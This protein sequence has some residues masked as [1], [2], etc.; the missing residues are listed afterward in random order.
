MDDKITRDRLSLLPFDA[1]SPYLAGAVYVYVE[2][3]PANEE[4]IRRLITRYAGYP[5]FRG[6]VAL[7]NSEV[8][9]MGFGTQ[10]LPGQWWHDKVAA[11]VGSKHAA[12]QDAWVLVDLA[13][14]PAYRGHGIGT[15]LHNALLADLPYHNALLSTEVSNAGSRRLYERLGWRYLHPGF[16]FN[17][18]QQPFVVM[19]K[20]LR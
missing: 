12:L 2:T 13:V 1:S 4:E 17:P 14:D 18:G 15:F 10:S 3:W 11:H 19:N 16:V 6:Y 5:G 8:V 7:L 20:K 9:G